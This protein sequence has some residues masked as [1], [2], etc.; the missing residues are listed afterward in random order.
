MG[1]FFS[2]WRK[3]FF[4]KVPDGNSYKQNDADE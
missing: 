3:D 4:E 2:R 1:L